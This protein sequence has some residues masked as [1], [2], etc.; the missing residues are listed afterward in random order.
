MVTTRNY[1]VIGFILGIVS[2]LGTINVITYF[3]LRQSTVP[4]NLLGRVVAVTRMVSFASIPIGA[5]FG[6]YI[7][8]DGFSMVTVI[9][10]AGAIRTLTGIVANFTPLSNEK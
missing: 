9:L 5:W 4:Q 7:L 8:K 1:I 6:G 3:T 2:F 10:L